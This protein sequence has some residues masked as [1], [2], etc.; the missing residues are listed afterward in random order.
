MA[1]D[2]G[3]LKEECDK[4]TKDKLVTMAKKYQTE[5]KQWK[6]IT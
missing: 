2:L 1:T 6:G 3:D 5:V 4:F